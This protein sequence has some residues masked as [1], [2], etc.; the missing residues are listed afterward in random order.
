MDSPAGGRGESIPVYKWYSPQGGQVHYIGATARTSDLWFYYSLFVSL[1]F[2]PHIIYF[3]VAKLPVSKFWLF[4]ASVPTRLAG[5]GIMLSTC[6]SVCPSVRQLSFLYYQTCQHDILKTNEPI[7]MQ[8]RWFTRQGNGTIDFK[9]ESE[10]Q[11]S[12]SHEVVDRFVGVVEASFT[13]PYGRV[14]FPFFCHNRMIILLFVWYAF[15][16]K[17]HYI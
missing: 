4:Y 17:I 7:L 11:R 14:A 6:P 8:H 3:L 13:T 10:G 15:I 1:N 9:L 5:R 16:K 12:R 2:M